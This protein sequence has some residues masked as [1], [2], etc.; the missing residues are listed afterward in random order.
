MQL[1]AGGGSYGGGSSPGTWPGGPGGNP[2][3]GNGG[4]WDNDYQAQPAKNGT[5]ASGTNQG[6]GGGGGGSF[7]GDG[8]SGSSGI[9]II[10]YK[11]Q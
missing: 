11:F 7:G 2:G 8:G 3:A 10:R 4:A 1:V 9:V 6:M 5:P